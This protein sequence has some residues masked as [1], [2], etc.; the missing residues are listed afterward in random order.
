MQADACLRDPTL[1]APT[2][3]R[4]PSWVRPIPDRQVPRF[5]YRDPGLWL[6]LSCAV[7]FDAVGAGDTGFVEDELSWS[8]TCSGADRI[9][10]VAVGVSPDTG[11]TGIT[12]GAQSMTFVFG[13]GNDVVLR[14]FLYV[15]VAP[16]T[17]EHTITVSLNAEPSFSFGR[18]AS[19]TGAAQADQP[20]NEN[21]SEA[22]TVSS[23]SVG[24]TT[25]A[26]NCWLVMSGALTEGGSGLQ[27]GTGTT[28]RQGGAHPEAASEMHGIFDSDGAKSPAGL[29]SLQCEVTSGTARFALA[30]ASF[31]P[32]AASV[33]LW[34]ATRRRLGY[35]LGWTY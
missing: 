5:W 2:R 1:W 29:Y 18:S 24:V 31:A 4:R 28:M 25:V 27:A 22:T 3:R 23:D 12:Y 8:H 35:R 30:L 34:P 11:V 7:A 26:D 32:A 10:F 14:S 6:P 16:N 33:A 19:Y 17:G 15:L 21:G 20:D 9:L 13:Q